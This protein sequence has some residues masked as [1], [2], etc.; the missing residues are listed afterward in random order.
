[1]SRSYTSSSPKAPPWR[2]AGLLYF[3]TF[4]V[5]CLTQC[6]LFGHEEAG[7]EYAWPHR[8]HEKEGSCP[9][10]M[11]QALVTIVLENRACLCEPFV[12]GNDSTPLQCASAVYKYR[13][14]FKH[15]CSPTEYI[16]LLLLQLTRRNASSKPS[17]FCKLSD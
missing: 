3:F 9:N 6:I 13:T 16:S 15:M 7:G 12:K 8:Q 4:T 11:P 5:A 2:V 17:G 10:K 14:H 1:M